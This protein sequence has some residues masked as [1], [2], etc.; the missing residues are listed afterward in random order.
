MASKG[1]PPTLVIGDQ[2]PASSGDQDAARA[3]GR[4]RPG[5]RSLRAIGVLEGLLIRREAGPV[6]GFVIL[7]AIFQAMSGQFISNDEMSAIVTLGAPIAIVSVG[8]AFLMISGEFD[9]SVGGV[10]PLAAILLGEL[11]QL[12]WNQWLSMAVVLAVCAAI[13]FGNGVITTAFRIPS[14][15]TTLAALYILRGVAYFVTNGQT[16]LIFTNSDLFT[17]LGRRLG[18]SFMTAVV[19][20]AI[21]IAIVMWFIL[22]HTQYGNWTFA[23]GGAERFAARHGRAEH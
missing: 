5:R 11:L 14:L 2:L 16:V 23:A 4:G 13:G 7:A 12:G 9:L 10:Y 15:I 6:V 22:Q 8:V 17:L 19:L 1:E 18:S 3:G 21:G 20:W